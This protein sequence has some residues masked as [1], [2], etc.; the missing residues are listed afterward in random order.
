MIVA[1]L[2]G[3]KWQQCLCHL[4]DVIL[5][6]TF[7]ELLLLKSAFECIRK[8]GLQLNSKKCRS[9]SHEIQI[10]DHSA[11]VV[12]IHPD[13]EETRAVTELADPTDVKYL[14]SFLGLYSYFRRFIKAFDENA[15]PLT[16]LLL[17]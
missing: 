11:N 12:G 3:L 10:L 14:R 1:L 7:D 17:N 2:W 9:A 6:A 16:S 5:F 8:A 13:P 15:K 4:G